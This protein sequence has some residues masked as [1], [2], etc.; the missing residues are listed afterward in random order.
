MQAFL[1][2]AIG[3]IKVEE[4]DLCSYFI[5]PAYSI[6]PTLKK[7]FPDFKRKITFANF[8]GLPE[9]LEGRI[10]LYT[11]AELLPFGYKSPYDLFKLIVQP[12]SARQ[13]NGCKSIW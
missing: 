10:R 6:K 3:A 4:K 2:R 12:G 7:L 9:L 5:E 8:N 1:L 11:L 13:E